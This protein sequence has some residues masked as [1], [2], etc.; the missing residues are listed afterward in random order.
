MTN[1]F[2]QGNGGQTPEE[3]WGVP[4]V[5]LERPGDYETQIPLLRRTVGFVKDYE[6]SRP[7][8][9]EVL[10]QQFANSIVKDPTMLQPALSNLDLI[11][12]MK[13]GVKKDE[14]VA[15]LVTGVE[16]SAARRSQL[17]N[18]TPER[19]E[20]LVQIGLDSSSPTVTEIISRM[21]AALFN[22]PQTTDEAVDF[23]YNA[24]WVMVST[25]KP[26]VREE[27][28]SILCLEKEWLTGKSLSAQFFS[29]GAFSADDVH[30]A[31][32]E[33]V[34]YALDKIG[35]YLETLNDPEH[36][37]VDSAR[38]WRRVDRLID[39]KLNLPIDKHLKN[40]TEMQRLY[41]KNPIRFQRLVEHHA[42]EEYAAPMQHHNNNFA[43]IIERMKKEKLRIESLSWPEKILDDPKEPLRKFIDEKLGPHLWKAMWE[44]QIVFMNR[45][46]FKKITGR[47][48]ELQKGLQLD[49]LAKNYDSPE[50]KVAVIREV[51]ES[52]QQGKSTN[53][54]RELYQPLDG[55][56]ESFDTIK[57][58]MQYGTWDYFDSAQTIFYTLH[59]VIPEDQIGRLG[60]I[61]EVHR[62]PLS[63]DQVR[64]AND[65]VTQMRQD[66]KLTFTRS[67][68]KRGHELIISDPILRQF[69][70]Q[71]ILFEQQNEKIKVKIKIDRES[72]EITLGSDYRVLLEGD[73]KKF[74]SPQDQAWLELLV[75]SHLKKVMCTDEEHIAKELVGGE[76]QAR[77]YRKQFVNKQDHLRRLPPKGL[78]SGG[79]NFSGEYSADAFTKCLGSSLPN[80]NLFLINQER[81]ATPE[82]GQWT[83]VSPSEKTDSDEIKPVK[84]A[85]ATA[86]AD[87][88]A[89]IPLNEVSQE[90]LDR[91]EQEIFGEFETV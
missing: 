34:M 75:L 38:A 16:K 62:P 40:Q 13:P 65:Q 6:R 25:T 43:E 63:L 29:N 12:M 72:Y 36:I 31:K 22:T 53:P 81:G 84:V 8:G 26:E 46:G 11:S 20:Q 82:S 47:P 50:Q 18:W 10:I 78:T 64:V 24:A 80:K 15:R 45:Q 32:Y 67:V 7:Q 60:S 56:L 23:H 66:I 74:E 52:L 89:I 51:Y 71:S 27:L 79:R 68:G 55:A 35:V 33:A 21:Q 69:G 54:T 17:G 44:N 39:G 58:G 61:I 91:I 2:E 37:Y 5:V 19:I 90:E 85:F 77:L 70:Y 1:R 3:L 14:I 57:Y 42:N 87:I 86:S 48:I 59:H 41:Q 28:F 30:L 4:Y 88:R 49:I 76:K 9:R 83:Y 73:V